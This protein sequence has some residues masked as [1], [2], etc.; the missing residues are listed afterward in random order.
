[1]AL[2]TIS[3]MEAAVS[4][5]TNAGISATQTRDLITLGEN[6]I[7]R[8]LRVRAME[9]QTTIAISS[10]SIPVPSDYIELKDAHLSNNPSVALQRTTTDLIYQKNP[11]RTSGGQPSFIARQGSNFVFDAYGD[12]YSVVLNYYAKPATVIGSTLTGIILSD[13]GI[14]LYASLCESA[15]Y[16]GQDQ[17]LQMWEAKYASIKKQIE[18][19]DKNEY[20]SGSVLTV[21]P[22]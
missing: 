22:G 7:Y 21:T 3:G 16:L 13:P 20:F 15:P 11:Y 4:D 6:R 17:R 12:G 5:W 14:L 10:G 18:D 9:S 8:E 2:N 1:M 19:R